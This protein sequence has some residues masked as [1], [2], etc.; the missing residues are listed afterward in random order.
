[1][2][3]PAV[4]GWYSDPWDHAQLRYWDGSEWTSHAS[5]ALAPDDGAGAAAPPPRPAP[6]AMPSPATDAGGA[7]GQAMLYGL[8]LGTVAGIASGTA[9]APVI[10]TV[11]GA[12]A[13]AALA[14]PVSLLAAWAISAPLRQPGDEHAYRRRLDVT[15]VVLGVA[16]LALAIGWISLE[17]LVGPW[18]ALAMLVVVVAGLVVARLRLR[19][20]VS[21]G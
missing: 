6:G 18:P 3:H 10:G 21:T 20:L 1:M 4:A 11:L 15:L 12:F 13:G 17:P 7:F 19:R 8:A 16:T 9:A 2:E 14:T 5:P